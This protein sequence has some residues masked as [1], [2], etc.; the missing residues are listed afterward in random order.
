MFR[1]A[2]GITAILLTFLVSGC[3]ATPKVHRIK[4]RVIT[5]PMHIEKGN[6]NFSFYP[7]PSIAVPQYTAQLN[8]GYTLG[9]LKLKPVGIRRFYFDNLQH[10]F[11]AFI[12]GGRKDPYYLRKI[13]QGHLDT[14][15]LAPEKL[16]NDL[17][18]LT[19]FDSSGNFIA[20]PDINRNRDFTDDSTHIYKHLTL[21]VG[22]TLSLNR[23]GLPHPADN[24]SGMGSRKGK[25]FHSFY[26]LE[27]LDT[28]HIFE[29][30]STDLHDRFDKNIR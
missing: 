4:E 2:A 10:E 5:I 15:S 16:K 27:A 29:N 26:S 25:I 9:R 19:G 23:S 30:K 13:Q 7:Q 11:I 8:V 6:R 28:S 1:K 24:P 3:E 22:E 20:V 21:T 14:S 18:V 12:E 17:D